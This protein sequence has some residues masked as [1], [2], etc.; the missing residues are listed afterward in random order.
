MSEDRQKL[1]ELSI[2]QTVFDDPEAFELLG[3]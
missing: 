3:G 2:P 1:K